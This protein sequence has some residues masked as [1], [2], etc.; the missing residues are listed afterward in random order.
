MHPEMLLGLLLLLL[1]DLWWC[2]GVVAELRQSWV[3]G[4]LQQQCSEACAAGWQLL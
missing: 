4:L 1:L 2:A 3:K